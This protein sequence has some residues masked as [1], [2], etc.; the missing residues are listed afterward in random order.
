MLSFENSL[1]VLSGLMKGS[2]EP[3]P[4]GHSPGGAQ[5][6]SCLPGQPLP[7]LLQQEMFLNL[8]N[9]ADLRADSSDNE[10]KKEL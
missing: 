10:K 1:P 9:A 5:L 7:C 2:P 3:S 6:C 8:N 4:A